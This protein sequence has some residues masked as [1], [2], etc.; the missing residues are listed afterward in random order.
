MLYPGPLYTG[1]LC[2]K[3]KT[4]ENFGKLS[5]DCD[6]QGERYI[7]GRYIQVNFAENKIQ[8]KILSNCPV[9]LIYGVIANEGRY[10]LYYRA[11]L[12]RILFFVCF[13]FC[14]LKLR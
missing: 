1:Q 5:G 2:R 13:H 14:L 7:Q 11:L 3:Y 10:I 8:L 9:T 4:T 6:V 12:R